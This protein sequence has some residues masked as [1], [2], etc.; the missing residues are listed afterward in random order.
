[1]VMIAAVSSFFQ[2]NMIELC[3]N[4]PLKRFWWMAGFE[5]FLLEVTFVAILGLKSK[6]EGGWWSKAIT[7]TVFLQF[8]YILLGGAL[9]GLA[10]SAYDMDNWIIY[11]YVGVGIIQSA[12]WLEYLLIGKHGELNESSSNGPF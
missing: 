5:A 9:S 4:S 12:I 2:I 7:A 11:I 3:R 1:M 10:F 6:M 8:A